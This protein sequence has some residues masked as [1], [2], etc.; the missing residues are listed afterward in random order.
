ML[1]YPDYNRILI[2]KWKM[3]TMAQISTL[4][5]ERCEFIIRK[6]LYFEKNQIN[7][8]MLSVSLN[9]LG[10][11]PAELQ[12]YN[13][14]LEKYDRMIYNMHCEMNWIRELEDGCQGKYDYKGNISD[15]IN[16]FARIF[17]YWK[18]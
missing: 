14:Q 2:E 16:D 13:D 1:N 5:K 4:E 12:Y 11:L 10:R 3:L 8:A 17:G 6:K 9:K 15:H 18:E 7:P